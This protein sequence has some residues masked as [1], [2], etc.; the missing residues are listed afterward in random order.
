MTFPGTIFMASWRI[1]FS[2]PPSTGWMPGAAVPRTQL[3]RAAELLAKAKNPVIVSGRGV[4]DAD[5][6]DIVKAI[7]E[8]LTAPVAVTYLHNDAFYGNHPLSVGP[9]GY[10]GSKAAMKT[11]AK[12]DVMLAIG[13]RL[14]VFGTLPQYDINYFP[15]NAKIIQVDINPKHIARTHPIEVGIIGDAKDATVEILKRLKAMDKNRKPDAKRLEAVAKQKKI[16]E[17]EIVDLAMVKGNPM[18][19]RRVLLEIIPVAAGQCHCYHRYRECRLH[20]Q[21]LSQVQPVAPAYCRPDLRQ[22]RFCLSGSSG[23]PARLPPKI[24]LSPSSATAPGG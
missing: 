10:M 11:L 21:Q 18:N 6:L 3:D 7:A 14:S 24:R 13:T 5:A 17:K 4:V 19:P 23:S 8:H 16:W 9:I 12:A 2:S 1:Q 15:D 22:Y 20:G